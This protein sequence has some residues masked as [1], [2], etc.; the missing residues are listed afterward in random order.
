MGTRPEIQRTGLVDVEVVAEGL[1]FPE[2]P[3]AMADGSVLVGEI[4]AGR[5]T[6]C[7]AD[8]TVSTVAEVG[9]GPNG[10]AIGPDAAVY[11]CNNGGLGAGRGPGSIQ[12]VDPES[13]DVTT[14]YDHSAAG[15]LVAPNDIVFDS[16]GRMWF[17][18]FAAG[19]IHRAVADGSAIDVVLTGLG[20]PNGIGLSPDGAVLYWAETYARRV[21]RRRVT[22]T[23]GLEPAAGFDI[24]AVLRGVAEPWCLLAGLPGAHELDS[25]AVDSAGAVCVGTLADSGVT[26]IS[27]DGADIVLHELPGVLRDGAV[28]NVCFGGRDLR[29]IYLTCSE[30]GRLVRATWHRP[31]LALEFSA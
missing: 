28:T 4:R 13:G 16:T 14:L 11:V 22:P 8:G 9:G 20:S 6:R 7:G 21:Q 25:L 26:E 10:L 12:R 17:T 3:V 5:V 1:A 27:A 30:H 18:D 15:A 23:G 19:R 29:T 24:H 2:G 31:G